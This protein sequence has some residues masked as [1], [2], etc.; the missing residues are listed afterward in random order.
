MIDGFAMRDYPLA[1]CAV[2]DQANAYHGKSVDGSNRI[3]TKLG[4]KFTKQLS[5]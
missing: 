2:G 3:G 4:M 5:Q 1:H